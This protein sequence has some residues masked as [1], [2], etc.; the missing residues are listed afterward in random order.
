MLNCLVIAR[1][2][3]CNSSITDRELRLEGEAQMKQLASMLNPFLAG[4]SSLRIYT[5]IAQWTVQSAEILGAQFDIR[6]ISFPALF[7]ADTN[8]DLRNTAELLARLI[9]IEAV[10]LM[11]HER[12]T[13]CLAEYYAKTFLEKKQRFSALW[14]GEAYIFDYREKK[15]FKIYSPDANDRLEVLEIKI[16]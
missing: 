11:T 15:V 2:G 1:H 7:M 8:N 5:S 13:S 4:L 6:P 3:L 9:D 12:G 14:P 10:I 16:P